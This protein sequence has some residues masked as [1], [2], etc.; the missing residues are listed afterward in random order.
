[1]SEHR[2][3]LSWLERWQQT[4]PLRLHL[5]GITVPLL[6]A[7]VTY[8]WLNAD[9]LGA[10]LAVAGALFLGSSLAGELARRKVTPV[11]GPAVERW[12]DEVHRDSYTRGVQDALHTT[13]EQTAE[14]LTVRPVERC[15]FIENGR[16]CVL[17]KHLSEKEG[18]PPHHY[19]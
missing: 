11:H 18:G 15:R 2:A 1:M 14:M 8:G 6:A 7:A 17:D 3:P 13:P 19:G 16:R 4:E 9:Q 10:W 5:Y 12:L